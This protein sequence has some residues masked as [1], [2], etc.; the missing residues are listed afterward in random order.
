M[1]RADVAA[2]LAVLSIACGSSGGGPTPETEGY[3]NEPGLPP[4]GAPALALI[5]P[6]PQVCPTDDNSCLT[7]GAADSPS[8]APDALSDVADAGDA[9][10]E[11]GAGVVGA[12]D[13]GGAGTTGDADADA[14]VE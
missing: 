4:P 5:P 11:A 1:K 3:A 8:D 6:P 9:P 12:P 7:D 14:S 13:T 2:V 10:G